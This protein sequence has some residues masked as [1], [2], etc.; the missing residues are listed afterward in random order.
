MTKE[1]E[2]ILTKLRSLSLFY[3]WDDIFRKDELVPLESGDE[4]LNSN[5]RSDEVIIL[6]P[7]TIFDLT[8]QITPPTTPKSSLKSTSS[9]K[10][11][12][13][14]GSF[15]RCRDTL[16][17]SYY[18]EFNQCAFNSE[19]PRDLSITWNKRMTKTAGFTK[20]KK[21]NLSDTPRTAT[22]ELSTKV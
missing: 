4:N 22:I 19:L 20:M 21:Y 9:F 5:D 15:S 11:P 10:T 2:E 3:R 6:D 12:K 14:P 8:S 16:T 1:E 7:P 17:A 13:S 18:D